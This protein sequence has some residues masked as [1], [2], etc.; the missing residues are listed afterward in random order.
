MSTA[1]LPEP[2]W[3]N[4]YPTSDGRP[5]AETDW[6]RELMFDLIKT[7]QLYFFN[8]AMVYVSGNLLLFYEQGNRRRHVSPDV[9]VVKGVPKR[10]RPNY[11]L[12][13]EGKAPGFVIE[14][15]SSSTRNEDVEEKFRLYRD[16][17]RVQ[18]YFLF[19]PFGDY[20]D[21][22][23]RGYRLRAGRYA[24]I[25]PVDGRLPSKVVGLHLERNG[26][27]LRLYDPAAGR[28][29]PTPAEQIAEAEAGLA[30]AEAG[31][32]E[33]EAEN[34]RLRREVEELRRRAEGQ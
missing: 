23:L 10:Q 8:N 3:K 29:L 1:I 34:E 20:L 33:A 22:P 13:E 18:E 12:W 25:R 5:M 4:D 30:E 11:L 15:T 32:A 7:L 14:L 19:D 31:L 16:T 28:W 2:S 24:S 21:P 6:H 26:R 17:L 27:D 9:F